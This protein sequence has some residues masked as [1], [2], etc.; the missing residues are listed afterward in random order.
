LPDFRGDASI[1]TWLCRLTYTASIDALRRRRPEAPTDDAALNDL[2]PVQGDPADEIVERAA[3]RSA[4]AGL[5]HEH[6][7][8]VLLVDRVGYDYDEAAEILGVASGTIASRLSRAR[9]ALRQA[10]LL[11]AEP[12]VSRDEDP[13]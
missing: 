11:T 10:I 8:S 6:Q 5:A 13:R 9:A 3:L 1:G 4:F 7:L 12:S 2:V